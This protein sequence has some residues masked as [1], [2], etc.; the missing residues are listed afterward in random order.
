MLS[1]P[2][3]CLVV[4]VTTTLL[5]SPS[6]S[7]DSLAWTFYNVKL[8]PPTEVSIMALVFLS[9]IPSPDSCTCVWQSALSEPVRLSSPELS[10]HISRGAKLFN[11]M[12][13]PTFLLSSLLCFLPLIIYRLSNPLSVAVN[14]V[15]CLS[16]SPPPPCSA[17]RGRLTLNPT[18]DLFMKHIYNV[19]VLCRSKQQDRRMKSSK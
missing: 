16:F 15:L 8:S 5:P 3:T 17:S 7:P 2:L 6:L 9:S 13:S 19:Y 10:K 1:Y 14:S 18:Q 12:A 4:S 11:Q